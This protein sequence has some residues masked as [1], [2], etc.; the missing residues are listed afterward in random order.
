MFEQT[1]KSVSTARPMS[2]PSRAQSLLGWGQYASFAIGI[3]ALTYAI[4][5]LLDARLYQ[6]Y[7]TS[8]FKQGLKNNGESISNNGHLDLPSLPG[9]LQKSEPVGT[10]A[11]D[12]GGRDGTPFGRIEISR[13]GLGAMIL[14]GTDGATLRRAV[15][16]ISGTARPGQLGNL[17][18]AA[19]RDTFF[20]PLRNIRRDDVITLATYDGSYSYQVD[21]TM[22]VKPEDTY[23]LDDSG[24][25]ILT[26]VTCYPFEFVGSAPRRFIVRA[27]RLTPEQKVDR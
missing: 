8:R 1:K 23:V 19:H 26:L 24:E 7:Q 18:L 9:M 3:L 22:V 6:E 13:I 5:V 16:H 11:F 4:S 17:A 25:A 14:E 27:H 12:I 15:G 20:R 2:R 21:S 10:G